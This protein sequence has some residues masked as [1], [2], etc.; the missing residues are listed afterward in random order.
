MEK[1]W[2]TIQAFLNQPREESHYMRPS[3]V[4]VKTKPAPAGGRPKPPP[5]PSKPTK[6]RAR[7]LYAYDKTDNNEIDSRENEVIELVNT[8]PSLNGWYVGL[9]SDGSQGFF[10]ASYCEKI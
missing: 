1:N 7:V 8:D 6:P 4:S 2:E 10:P 9:K 3:E 5:R